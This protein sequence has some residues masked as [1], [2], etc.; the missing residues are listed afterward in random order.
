MH[1]KKGVWLPI[2]QIASVHYVIKLDGYDEPFNDEWEKKLEYDGFNIE[3]KDSLG[4]SSIGKFH[5]FDANGFCGN[6]ISYQ[7]YDGVTLYSAFKYYEFDLS[8]LTRS[9]EAVIYWFSE[10]EGGRKEPPAEEEYCP[11]IELEDRIYH[12]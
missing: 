9:K 6:K 1:S 3:I 4:I 2:V 7:T 8:W 5:E 11:T 12:M 10:A